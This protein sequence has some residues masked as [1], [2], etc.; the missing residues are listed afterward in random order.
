MSVPPQVMAALS[1]SGQPQSPAAGHP[2]A[3]MGSPMATPQANH[4]E[5]EQAHAKVSIAVQLL[6]Q[7]LPQFGANSVEGKAL[8]RAL[9]LLSK[10][11]G[12]K[13]SGDLVPAQVMQMVHALPQMGGGTPVQRA[14]LAQMRSGQSQGAQPGAQPQPQPPQAAQ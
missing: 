11:F 6:E 5:Q 14:L 3:P 13:D 2:A 12:S 9:T 7:S 8:L 4:G 1:R 10:D